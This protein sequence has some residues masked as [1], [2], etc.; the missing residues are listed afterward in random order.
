MR[1][2][3]FYERQ[4][5]LTLKSISNFPQYRPITAIFNQFTLA[6]LGS[7][8]PTIAKPINA[9]EEVIIISKNQPLI[10]PST[11]RQFAFSPLF[12]SIMAAHKF[13]GGIFQDV[14]Q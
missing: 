13:D 10:R 5:E 1:F 6:L 3:Q 4:F 12:L 7:F 8:Q 14:R 9:D 11:A 2:L